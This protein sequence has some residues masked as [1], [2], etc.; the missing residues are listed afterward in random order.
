VFHGQITKNNPLT[1]RLILHKQRPKG[2]H[3]V[4]RDVLPKKSGASQSHL[5]SEKE[6]W[7]LSRSLSMNSKLA[8]QA[9]DIYRT[10]MQIEEE[11][12]DINSRFIWPGI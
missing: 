4:N 6:P 5:K 10:R 8:K 2:R 3:K 11:F 7:L 9:V 1:C 12:R